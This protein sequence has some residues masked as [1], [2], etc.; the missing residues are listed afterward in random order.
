MYKTN[1]N[2]HPILGLLNVF[3]GFGIVRQEVALYA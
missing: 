3:N 2:N 1:H